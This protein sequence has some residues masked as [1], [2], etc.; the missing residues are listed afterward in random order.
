MWH[1]CL[2]ITRLK[3]C[4]V[5]PKPWGCF[6][7]TQLAVWVRSWAPYTH[8]PQREW[9]CQLL[10]PFDKVLF[11]HSGSDR[12]FATKHWLSQSALSS[13]QTEWY[14]AARGR[15]AGGPSPPKSK[16]T[17]AGSTR[18]HWPHWTLFYKWLASLIQIIR[19]KSYKESCTPVPS[20][21]WTASWKCCLEED[22]WLCNFM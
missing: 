10:W 16:C 14:Y 21:S 13:L 7:E 12:T 5:I 8:S 11:S 3:R 20:G 2:T 22:D 17:Q 4:Y 1:M 9:I 19:L 15:L 6:H 18:I